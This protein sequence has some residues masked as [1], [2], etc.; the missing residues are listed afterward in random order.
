MRVIAPEKE[1]MIGGASQ[2]HMEGF[3]GRCLKTLSTARRGQASTGNRIAVSHSAR[4]HVRLGREGGLAEIRR[5][6]AAM[7]KLPFVR[8]RDS[9]VGTFSCSDRMVLAGS[10][11]GPYVTHMQT[12]SG[13]C[14]SALAQC[15]ESAA[16]HER[17]PDGVCFVLYAIT[18]AALQSSQFQVSATSASEDHLQHKQQ[19]G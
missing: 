15:N 2:N 16:S 10:C 7:T 4:P 13:V 19:Q 5:R 9:S 1:V 17:G 18:V 8:K 14:L 3:K 12:Q 11:E 6:T